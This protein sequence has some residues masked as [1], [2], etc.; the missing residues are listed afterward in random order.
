MPPNWR[1]RYAVLESVS[2]LHRTREC[3]GHLE[4]LLSVGGFHGA[5]TASRGYDGLFGDVLLI[6]SLGRE[7]FDQ[8]FEMVHKC[9]DCLCAD[10]RRG[11]IR[12][13]RS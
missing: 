1:L 7:I 3:L 12:R 9:V 6:E 2:L 10:R 5:R 11:R 13:R 8:G 4:N